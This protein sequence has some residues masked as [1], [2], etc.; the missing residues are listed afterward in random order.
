MAGRVLAELAL[1]TPNHLTRF[2]PNTFGDLQHDIAH[3]SA[4]QAQTQWCTGRVASDP[5]VRARASADAVARVSRGRFCETDNTRVPVNHMDRR[6]EA[7]PFTTFTAREAISATEVYLVGHVGPLSTS[8]TATFSLHQMVWAYPNRTFTA[9]TAT[10]SPI[11][12]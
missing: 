4:P 8:P 3:E 6:H 9:L 7:K 12:E 5:T 2:P 1:H 11:I 10:A